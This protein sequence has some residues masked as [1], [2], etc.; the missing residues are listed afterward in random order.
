MGSVVALDAFREAVGRT[1]QKPQRPPRPEVTGAE[2]W[3]RDYLEVESI[4]YG[5]LTARAMVAHHT[6]GHDQEFDSLSIIA[7]EAA[8][9]IED[10]GP[11]K[12]K[13]ALKP[14]KEWILD[15][16]TEDNKR[17]MSW[18]L[19]LLDLIEKSPLK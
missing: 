9:H 12:L 15:S 8:Y 6:G 2:V 7:L 17:D 13:V 4:V 14:L 18:C 10:M 3:G 11:A 5:L 1:D 19:V 16:M